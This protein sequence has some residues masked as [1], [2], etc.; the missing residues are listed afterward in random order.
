M[1]RVQHKEKLG[2]RMGLLGGIL[3]I[4]GAVLF[5]A[6]KN[7]A[8]DRPLDTRQKSA[9]LGE[10]RDADAMFAAESKYGRRAGNTPPAN[11]PLDGVDGET[12]AGFVLNFD[13]N[14]FPIAVEIGALRSDVQRV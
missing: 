10:I 8:G 11:Q 7:I 6:Q 12:Q 2:E 5:S 3:S 14:R 9:L 13:R 4:R 1:H